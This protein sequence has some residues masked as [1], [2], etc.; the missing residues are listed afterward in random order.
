MK[1]IFDNISLQHFADPVP[2][3][4]TPEELK[5]YLEGQ[6][7]KI[8]QLGSKLKAL[9]GYVGSGSPDS[10]KGVSA[11]A[12]A[13]CNTFL[14]GVIAKKPDVIM[15]SG[16]SVATESDVEEK[17]G[18]GLVEK[19]GL[20][21]EMVSDSTTGSY[22]V[23]VEMFREVIRQA[24]QSSVLLP[25]LRTF[26]MGS[27]TMTIPVKSTAAA[28]TWVTSQG[29]TL[30][31]TSPTFDQ[32]TLTAYTLAAWIAFNESFFEDEDASVFNYFVEEFGYDLADEIDNQV[33]NGTGTPMTG[34]FQDASVNEVVMGSGNSSFSDLD[35][36]DLLD[37]INA[38][39]YKKYQR[40][41]TFIC[42][43]SVMHIIRKLNDANGRPI[44]VEGTMSDPTQ[45]AGYPIRTSD[46]APS[47]SGSS[48][49]F[50]CFGNFRHFA[51]GSRVGMEVKYF[52][53]TSY[54]VNEEEVFIRAR[55]RFAGVNLIPDAFAKLTTA[56]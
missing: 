9:K 27:R 16:G 6:E 25:L 30:T 41:G 17:L 50:I 36:N 22:V 38:V 55:G 14:K 37:L 40:G 3:F 54:A 10:P 18:K 46:A 51:W 26:P 24:G 15:A 5:S 7:A 12:V 33:L 45:I 56:A 19:A 53:N 31:E 13:R 29:T 39:T 8:T 35:Y 32:K 1:N 21:T 52:G 43:P 34:I 28:L 23:P 42:H 44:L 11:E 2:D 47:T 4:G 49:S 48:T 20:G